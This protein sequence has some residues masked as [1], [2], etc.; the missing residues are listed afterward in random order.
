M[1]HDVFISFASKDEEVAGKIHSHLQ[2]RGIDCFWCKDLPG[3]AKYVTELGRAIR[4]S[5][6]LLLVFSSAADSSDS[7]INEVTIAH[8]NRIPRIP[9]RLENVLP[10]NLE[11]VLANSL[12]FD[13]FP[14]PLD[15]YLPQ[16]VAYIRKLL[17]IKQGDEP[18][19]QTKVSTGKSDRTPLDLRIEDS[20]WHEID[21]KDLSQWVL[22]RIKEL[23]SGR[24]VVARTFIYRRNK[25]TGK[26]E[27]KLK[28][29]K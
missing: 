2:D 1:S 19:E 3:G 18:L 23:D 10:V 15:Y 4:E 24:A 12:F 22:S 9:L 14:K 27:R 7:V 28:P 20:R 13:V 25:F 26:Y 6:A 29:Q 17:E 8:N 16:L 21:R 11:Y 5:K